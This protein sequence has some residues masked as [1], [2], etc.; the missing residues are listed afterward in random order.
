M[1]KWLEKWAL[2]RLLKR[3]AEQI[4]MA[5]DRLATIW[6]EH[7]DEIF[8]KV[9]KAIK[10]AVSDVIKKALEKQGIEVLDCSDN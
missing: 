2:K 1:I 7:K 8:E 6:Q 10:K 4:P 9:T 5:Q 3:V